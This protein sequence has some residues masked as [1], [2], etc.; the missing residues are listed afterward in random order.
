MIPMLYNLGM[1]TVKCPNCG[2]EV[3]IIPFGYGY[4]AICCGM[5]LYDSKDEPPKAEKK[6]EKKKEEKKEE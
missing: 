1:V 6:E 5:I 4:M 3:K 2:K